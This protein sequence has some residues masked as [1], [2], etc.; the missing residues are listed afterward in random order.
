MTKIS[1]VLGQRI[2]YY[3]KKM[4][5]SQEELAELADLHPTYIGQLERGEK[6]ASIETIYKISIAL[7]IPLIQLLEK[8]D[9]YPSST[10]PQ[11]TITDISL[12]SENIPLQAYELFSLESVEN[13]RKLMKL[14]TYALMLKN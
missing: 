2:R 7:Q 11:N 10:F 9:E 8:I 3:R 14:L 5:L 4:K 1:E 6:N 13:Q 12:N